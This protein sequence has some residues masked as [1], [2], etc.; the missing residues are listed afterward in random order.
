M[1]A[2]LKRIADYSSVGFGNV[3]SH[4]TESKLRSSIRIL[5][6][7]CLFKHLLAE[8][9]FMFNNR[10]LRR[11]NSRNPVKFG[12]MRKRLSAGRADL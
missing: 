1:L 9:I 6:R 10:G 11:T 2:A 5:A 3:S 12:C 8:S 4:N 7:T